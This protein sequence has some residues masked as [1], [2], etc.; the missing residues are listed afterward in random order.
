MTSQHGDYYN[1]EFV[2]EFYDFVYNRRINVD[3]NFFVDY[4]KNCGGHTLELGCGTGRTLIPTATAGCDITGLDLSPYMLQRCQ[5]KLAT[6]PGVVQKRVKLIQGNI[7]EF[8]T[9]EKYSL[10][11]IPF[12]P[13]QHLITIAE[14]KACLACVYQ[15]LEPP[16]RLVF[17]VF[18]PNPLRLFPNPKFMEEMEDLPETTMPDGRKVR[19]TNR[20]TGFHRE[21]QYN[22]YEIRYYVTYPDGRKETLVQT[23][24]LRY[25]FRY[26]ME[27]LLELCRFKVIDLFGDFKKSAFTSD[28]AE[29]IFVAEKK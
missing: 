5:E 12:R 22:E 4:A 8:N 13:F 15:H 6:Q 29:M 14:Q 1:K 23:F 7:T 9:G 28:S 11:T 20:Q 16:G 17:D 26:E 19:R 18:N 24:P 2:A 27:H 3:V 21:L 25:Y 10:V